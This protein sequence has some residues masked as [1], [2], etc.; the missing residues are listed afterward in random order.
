MTQDQN[1]KDAN[2]KDHMTDV[3]ARYVDKLM[4]YPH[5]VGVALGTA[6]VDGQPTDE[7]AI[8]VLV[9]EKIPLAQL[10]PHEVLP[11]ELDGVRVDV[12]ASGVFTAF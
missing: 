1:K 7:P 12:Q 2:A 9:D 3:Q 8:V 4:Q 10:A 5:V 11:S 6:Q